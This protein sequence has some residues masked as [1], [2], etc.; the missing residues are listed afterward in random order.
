L[1]PNQ[2]GEDS[3]ICDESFQTLLKILAGMD[4]AEFVAE[5]FGDD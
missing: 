4:H 1:K 3:D 2:F 5:N